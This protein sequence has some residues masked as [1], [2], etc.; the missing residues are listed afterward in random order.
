MHRKLGI[1][2]IVILLLGAAVAFNSGFLEATGRR[3][4][5]SKGA[6]SAK[7]EQTSMSVN[8]MPNSASSAAAVQ[9]SANRLA[10][11]N[12][13]NLDWDTRAPDIQTEIKRLLKFGKGEDI[14]YAYAYRSWCSKFGGDEDFQKRSGMSFED[15]LRSDT[16][17]NMGPAAIESAIALRRQYKKRCGKAV[18][19]FAYLKDVLVPQKALT[20]DEGRLFFANRESTQA[21]RQPISERAVNALEVVF[22]DQQLFNLETAVGR[23]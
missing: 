11:P 19:Q 22:D 16:H 23:M 4:A 20:P 1:L 17:K 2:A 21:F 9:S 10:I 7:P 13:Q 5:A 6:V 12:S 15:Y 3:G 18:D 8:V 14:S